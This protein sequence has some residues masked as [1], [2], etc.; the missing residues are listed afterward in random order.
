MKESLPIAPRWRRAVAT[1][2]VAS[3]ALWPLVHRGVVARFDVNPWK[4]GGLA[5]YAAVTPPVLVG[6]FEARPGGYRVIDPRPLPLWVRQRLEG[7]ERERH[8]L[9]DL[10]RPDDLARAVLEAR[11]DLAELSLLVQRMRLDPSS[12]AMV[13]RKVRYRYD[14]AGLLEQEVVPADSPAGS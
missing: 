7:F 4:L 10:R 8:A 12:A 3:A 13:S 9:G 14:R 5:M 2:V 1:A 6:L 11:P